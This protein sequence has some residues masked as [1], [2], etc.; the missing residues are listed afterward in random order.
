VFVDIPTRVTL[1]GRNRIDS[2]HEDLPS[3]LAREQKIPPAQRLNEQHLDVTDISF[4]KSA[5]TVAQVIF[6]HPQEGI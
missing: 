3:Q 2:Q 4:S 5:L 6:P 1:Q